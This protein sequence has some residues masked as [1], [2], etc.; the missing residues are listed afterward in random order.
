MGNFGGMLSATPWKPAER[1]KS[2][3]E[4]SPFMGMSTSGADP[5]ALNTGPS[6]NGRQRISRARRAPIASTRWL[7]M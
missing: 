5:V 6:R 1:R 3:R 7:A 4:Y 2:R